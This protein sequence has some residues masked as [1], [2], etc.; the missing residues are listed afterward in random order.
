MP[1]IY[2]DPESKAG[3]KV[4]RLGSKQQTIS[5][6]LLLLRVGSDQLSNHQDWQTTVD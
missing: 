2:I 4:S 5:A 1:L 3:S 6:F